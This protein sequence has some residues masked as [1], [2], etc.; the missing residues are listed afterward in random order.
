MVSNVLHDPEP[1]WTTLMRTQIECWEAEEQQMQVE[2]IESL[3]WEAAERASREAEEERQR[4]HEVLLVAEWVAQVDFE[5]A[6]QMRRWREEAER[7]ERLAR[8]EAEAHAS[9]ERALAERIAQEMEVDRQRWEAER[10]AAIAAREEEVRHQRAIEEEARLARQAQEEAERRAREAFEAARKAQAEKEEMERQLE[11]GIQPV[12]I[13]TAE[14]VQLAKA[15]VQYKDD[16][17]HFAVAGVAGSGKS[18]LINA[19]CGM[20]NR[21]PNAAPTGVSETTLEISRYVNSAHSEQFAW[22]DVPG[23]GTL[24]IP[25]WQYFNSQGLYV[26]DCILV[27]F[28]NRFT[29]TDHAILANCDRFKIP[30]FIVRSKSDQHILNVMKDVGYD[31]DEDTDY[32]EQFYHIA[33]EHYISETRLNVKSNLA[34]A[35]LRDQRV[36]IISNKTL[37]GVAKDNWPKK[38][39]DEFT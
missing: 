4:G 5:E 7:A 16:V 22:Y 1:E 2:E 30:T 35:N 11:R 36:Y 14:E 12:V 31:T 8:E 37:A 28:D 29:M 34:E 25:D 23:S 6:E 32:R 13:P 27:L 17:F 10:L 33:R 3:A 9:E 21:D 18:S 15:K 19:F 26:F 24:T 38:I 20:N 39:I